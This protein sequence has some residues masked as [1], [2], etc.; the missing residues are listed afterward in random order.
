MS[1]IFKRGKI[2][3]IDF[4]YK[5]KRIRQSLKTRCKRVA[6]LAHKNTDIQIAREELNISNFRRVSFVDFCERFLRWYGVQNSEKSYKDYRNL[7]NSTIIPY[8][9]GYYLNDIT[10]EMAEEYKVKRAEKIQPGTINKE[11]TALRHFFNKAIQWK[12]VAENPLVNVNRLKV[13]QKNFRFLSLGEIDLVLD[14]SPDYLRPIIL[15]AIHSGLRKSELFRLEWSDVDFERNCITVTA[16]GK[17]HT[18]NYK[19][20]EIHM[21]KQLAECLRNLEKNVK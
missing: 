3:Y 6:E 7:F 11:L 12:Y 5:G 20:R 8:F 18:K 21:T 17:E 16:K 10:S 19:N 14:S 1:R 15:T 13:S 9:K 2:W 4:E